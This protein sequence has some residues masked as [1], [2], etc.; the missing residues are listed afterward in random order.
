[1]INN[2]FPNFFLIGAAKA[3]STSVAH[4]LGEH[5]QIYLSPIKEP[6]YFSRADINPKHFR[7]LLKKR[8]ALF[9]EDK[10]FTSSEFPSLHAA[11]LT[12]EQHYQLLFKNAREDQVTGEASVSYL[13]S[14]TA[15]QEIFNVNPNAKIIMV[16]RN[17]IDRAFSHYLM[18]LRV[19]FT[20]MTFMEALKMDLESPF[21]TWNA[22]SKYIELGLY[23]AQIERYFTIFPKQNVKVILFD[24]LK[25]NTQ[26]EMRNLFD[27]LSVDPEFTPDY[28]KKYNESYLYK[29]EFVNAVTRNAKLSHFLRSILNENIKNKIRNLITAKR[30]NPT[31]TADERIYLSAF[32]KEDIAKTEKLL[33]INL[34]DWYK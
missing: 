12:N 30:K 15:P 28:N 20:K 18:D 29:N 10:Y 14:P 33:Q 2:N 3:G 26:L 11:Y 23:S 21:K 31:I 19:N 22:N 17:P 9:D 8:I 16:L 25:K 6:N 32:F 27:F 24:T 7:E 13:W 4:Y 1:M 5:S 34:S